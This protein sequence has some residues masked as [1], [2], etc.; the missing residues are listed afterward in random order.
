MKTILVVDDEKEIRELITRKL[1]KDFTV[2]STGSSEEALRI[3]RMNA[4]DLVLLD[5]AMPVIDGYA[6]G[7]KLRSDKNTEN[8]PIVF[9]TGKGL[10]IE[11]IEQHCKDLGFCDYIL[12]SASLSELVAKIKEFLA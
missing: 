6:M 11:H 1:S 12:K 8:T 3:C 5:I 10:D 2:L 9:L 7:E 4:P